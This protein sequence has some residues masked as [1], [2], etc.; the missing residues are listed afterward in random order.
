[1]DVDKDKLRKEQT[2]LA[3]KIITSDSFEKIELIAGVDVVY[4]KDTAVCAIA[5]CD[6]KM[7]LVESKYSV[8]ETKFPYLPGYLFYREGP[9]I[10]ETFH[11]LNKKPDILMCGNHGIL[12]PRRLG[13]ASHLGLIL[14]IPTIGVA[15]NMLIGSLQ[16]DS[17]IVDKE[18]RAAQIVTK[19]HANPLFVSQGHRISL[20]KAVE[21]VKNSI[22]PPHKLPEPLHIAHHISGREKKKIESVKETKSDFSE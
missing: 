9:I 6:K 11:K 10:I 16:G 3:S 13:S 8:A 17:V 12:H 5:V 19:E 7:N 21:I 4:V 15:K 2:E 20:K 1:M 14:D 18:V 22:H